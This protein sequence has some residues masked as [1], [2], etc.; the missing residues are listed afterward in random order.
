[1]IHD[2]KPDLPSEE[3]A[4]AHYGTKGMKWGVR[5]VHLAKVTKATNRLDAVSGG[6]ANKRQKVGTALT[7]PVGRLATKGLKG[8]AAK[9]SR[10]LKEHAD[11]LEK[12]EAKV[13]DIMLVSYSLSLRDLSKARQLA[14]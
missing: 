10:L 12:G 8:A 9:E 11:R 5:Q 1:M 6:T 7:L 13:R 2:D 4:L 3:E 14:K